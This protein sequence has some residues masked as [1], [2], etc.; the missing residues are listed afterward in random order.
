MLALA[1][2]FEQGTR[3]HGTE[4]LRGDGDDDDDDDYDDEECEEMRNLRRRARLLCVS[5]S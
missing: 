4:R 5:E 3:V 1:L 2:R